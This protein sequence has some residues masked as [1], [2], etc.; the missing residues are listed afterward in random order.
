M[1]STF[2]AAAVTFTLALVLA[3]CGATPVART[4]SSPT[5]RVSASPTAAAASPS[6]AA[7]P[8]QALQPLPGLCVGVIG[9]VPTQ[10]EFVAMTAASV[11]AVEKA[12]GYKDWSVCSNGQNCFRT[13]TAAAAMIGTDAA[14][15][16]GGYGQY[17]GG[18]LGAACWVFVYRDSAGWHFQDFGC[19][20]NGGFVPGSADT[21]SHVFVNGCA[22][23]RAM[24]G[25]SA[26]VL[27]CLSN[28]T[29]VN[30]DSAPV[31]LDGHI[32]WHLSGRGWMAHDYLCEICRV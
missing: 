13:G 8:C 12:L 20:Q 28:R 11:P 21:G 30:V 15:F 32:W 26:K 25:L 18:G 10:E 27:G 29:V 19:A 7:S 4:S 22:N 6:A 16:D 2:G 14:A 23:Y 1:R 24:P 3:A 9:R 31:F 17:P 5:A